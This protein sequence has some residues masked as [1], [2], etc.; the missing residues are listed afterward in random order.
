MYSEAFAPAP[1]LE[2]HQPS[3]TTAKIKKL[4]H[5]KSSGEFIEI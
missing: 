1:L 4:Q 5:L 2:A 3:Y